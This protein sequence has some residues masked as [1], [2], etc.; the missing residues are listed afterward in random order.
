M[1]ATKA[2]DPFEMREDLRNAVEDAMSPA[3]EI[4]E[5]PDARRAW[6]RA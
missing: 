2:N 1:V 4:D 3:D 6:L 5:L